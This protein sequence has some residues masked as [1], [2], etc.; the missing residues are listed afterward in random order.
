MRKLHPREGQQREQ[1]YSVQALYLVLI[2]LATL[3]S[4]V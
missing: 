2:M 3:Y 1:K 4:T